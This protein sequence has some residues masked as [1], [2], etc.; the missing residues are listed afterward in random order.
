M[1][2]SASCLIGIL[3]TVLAIP[4]IRSSSKCSV[5]PC[6][7]SSLTNCFANEAVCYDYQTNDG[8]RYCAPAS[9]CELFETCSENY[10]CK[11]NTSVCIVNSCCA[12]PICLPLVLVELCSSDKQYRPRNN[13]IHATTAVSSTTQQIVPTGYVETSTESISIAQTSTSDYF[14]VPSIT[15]EIFSSSVFR[16]K[17]CSTASWNPIGITVASFPNLLVNDFFVNQHDELYVPDN[18]NHLIRKYSPHSNNQWTAATASNFLDD[19]SEI[20]VDLDG[21]IYI[22]DRKHFRVYLWSSATNTTK[23]LLS[24]DN[25]RKAVEFNQ[26]CF[27]TS[28]FVDSNHSIYLSESSTKYHHANRVMKFEANS[29]VGQVIAG[30]YTTGSNRKELNLPR[31]VFTDSEGVLYVADTANS[32]IQQFV[33]NDRNGTT[34]VT[35]DGLTDF[36]TDQDENY[37]LL[38]QSKNLLQI[39]NVK[40]GQASTTNVITNL[41]QPTRIR[42]GKDGSIYVLNEGDHIIQKFEIRNNNC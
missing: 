3:S 6:V 30:T 27:G 4:T 38:I 34:V 10:H 26:I 28:I 29:T 18:Q 33:P 2:L 15:P 41:N 22:W 8:N 12:Q 35:A 37:F 19:P 24:F 39:M 13:G 14:T 7:N 17:I 25:C 11:S 9:S 40:S 20:F 42:F 32:R 23:T 16:P 1:H 5:Q 36:L 31:T 21:N